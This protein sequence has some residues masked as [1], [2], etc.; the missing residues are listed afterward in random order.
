M[1]DLCVPFFVAH[2]S[3]SWFVWL[4]Q[5]YIKALSYFF[6]LKEVILEAGSDMKSR[7]VKPYMNN[8]VSC[9]LGAPLMREGFPSQGYGD[10]QTHNT[11]HWIDEIKSS[12]LLTVLG[13][14]CS[15][16]ASYITYHK[17][18]IRGGRKKTGAIQGRLC[19]IKRMRCPLDPMGGSD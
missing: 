2:I 18:G 8:G 4:N 12:L 11:C 13:V 6:K 19:R 17:V 14:E 15:M 16:H 1:G 7:E 3:I 10:G 5:N 9:I